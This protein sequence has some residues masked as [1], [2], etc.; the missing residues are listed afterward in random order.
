MKSSRVEVIIFAIVGIYLVV[1]MTRCG[2]SGSATLQK[3]GEYLS[4]SD[5]D[6]ENGVNTELAGSEE[7]E[8]PVYNQQ[9]AEVNKTYPSIISDKKVKNVD[10][11]AI[12]GDSAY[13]LFTYRKDISKNYV[14]ALNSLA[15]QLE[16]KA[17]VYDMLVPLSSGIT[18]PDNLRDQ[19][20]SSDQREAMV[21][22]F[23]GISDKV[24]KVDIYD[25]LMSHL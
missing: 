19:I 1:S 17:K 2:R 24:S 7:L 10:S 16:G 14:K 22:I 9:D 12:V 15:M 6:V 20:K 23:D 4:E 8:G 3:A 18:F 13:E 11:V 5:K 21:D 25:T